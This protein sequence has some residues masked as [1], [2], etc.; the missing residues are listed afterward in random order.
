[1]VPARS[2]VC[3]NLTSLSDMRMLRQHERTSYLG[4]A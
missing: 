4:E 2:L 3:A 1:M